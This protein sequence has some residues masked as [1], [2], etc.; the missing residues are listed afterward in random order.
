M[1]RKVWSAGLALVLAA[2]C[3][4]AKPKVLPTCTSGGVALTLEQAA[5]AATVAAVGKR[6]G[7]PN[8]AVTI[9]LATALQ[10]SK[11][12][13]LGYGDR[14]SLGLFQQRPSQGWGTAAQVR[15][16]VHAA[17]AFYAHLRRVPGWQALPVTEAAQRVQRSAAP[18]A[19][20]Q[21]EDASRQLARA[22]TG[23]LAA[24]FA[25]Q[26]DR[27]PRPA[28]GVQ[29]QERA[30][31]ELG[32]GGLARTRTPAQ[33]WTTA[34]WLVAQAATYGISTVRVSGFD[35]NAKRGTWRRDPAAAGLVWS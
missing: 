34:S 18:Y 10:E 1:R 25:C 26:F 17:R 3:S 23:E 33:T 6:L 14:D 15:D 4:T 16:P 11:L 27:A 12:R 5:N 31:A 29:V 20:A 2:G 13:N 35:W 19:Y 24:G 32:P 21:W 8:H 7:L 22:L 30:T 9:A 28:G